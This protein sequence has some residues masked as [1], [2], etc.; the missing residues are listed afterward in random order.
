MNKQNQPRKDSVDFSDEDDDVMLTEDKESDHDK[1]HHEP[2][3][4]SQNPLILMAAEKIPE[5]IK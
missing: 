5:L 3:N 4:L 1:A 2:A